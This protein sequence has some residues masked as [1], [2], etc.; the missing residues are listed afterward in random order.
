MNRPGWGTF[1]EGD[2]II[3]GNPGEG[4]TPGRVIRPGSN[5]GLVIEV[6]EYGVRATVVVRLEDIRHANELVRFARES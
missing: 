5:G 2:E 4:E 6:V 3:W 1:A